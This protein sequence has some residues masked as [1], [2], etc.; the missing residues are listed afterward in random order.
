MSGF[1]GIAS[2]LLLVSGV[3]ARC[4]DWKPRLAADYLDSREKAWF[5]CGGQAVSDQLSAVS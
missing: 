1:P 3:T 5:A 2:I 4:G